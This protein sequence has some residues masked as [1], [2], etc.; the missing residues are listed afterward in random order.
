MLPPVVAA[1]TDDADREAA[2]PGLGRDAVVPCA[3]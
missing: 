1:A 2:R 3:A